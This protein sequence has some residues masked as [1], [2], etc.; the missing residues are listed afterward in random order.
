MVVVIV[1]AYLQLKPKEV[2]TPSPSGQT[3]TINNQ[4]GNDYRPNPN[5]SS[6]D[7]NLVTKSTWGISFIKSPTWNITTNTTDK[8]VVSQVV[9]DGNDGNTITL[10][11]I[12]GNSVTDSDAKFGNIT[13]YYDE[14][15]KAWM[16]KLPDEQYGGSMSPT[17]AK[18]AFYTTSGL[19]VF[20][21]TGRWGTYI[22]P[23]SSTTFLKLNIS[24]GGLTQPLID[25]TKTVKKI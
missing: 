23:L 18:P 6:V 25:L 13:Y 24:G 5:T 17:I 10:T 22:I 3:T 11:S 19:P 9:Q 12:S 15:S 1:L 4:N 7:S 8:V 14:N 16:V 2:T 21:G 20:N